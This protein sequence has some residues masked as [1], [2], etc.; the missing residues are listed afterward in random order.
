M[1]PHSSCLTATY[2]YTGCCSC[3]RPVF[4]LVQHAHIRLQCVCV[5]ED[6]SSTVSAPDATSV[7]PCGFF[8]CGVL[9]VSVD[10]KVNSKPRLGSSY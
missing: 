10:V 2:L 8:G 6:T 1:M 9:C 7:T 4:A 3:R 5:C